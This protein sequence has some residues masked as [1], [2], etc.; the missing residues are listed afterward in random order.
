ML[1]GVDDCLVLKLDLVITMSNDNRVNKCSR[2]RSGDNQANFPDVSVMNV[3]ALLD[4]LIRVDAQLGNVSVENKLLRPLGLRV[5][6][7]VSIRPDTVVN[8]GE[9]RVTEDVVRVVVAVLPEK[10]NLL[11][12]IALEGTGHDD[13]PVRALEAVPGCVPGEIRGRCH[14]DLQLLVVSP[15]LAG[16]KTSAEAEASLEQLRSVVV[17]RKLPECSC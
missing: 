12:V 2:V 4:K 7:E 6:V 5:V 1:P 9:N 3:L 8:I 17:Q 11:A 16:T 15:E 10:R 13:S 14:F